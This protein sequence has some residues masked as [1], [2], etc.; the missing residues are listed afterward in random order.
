MEKNF[1]AE[2]EFVTKVLDPLAHFPEETDKF[3]SHP[4]Q[5]L[6]GIH[7]YPDKLYVITVLENPLRW[8]SRY[9]NYWDFHKHVTDSGAILLTVELA[10][11]GRAFE[12]T[13]PDDPFNVQLRT[14]DEMFHKENLGNIGVWRLPLGVRYVALMDADMIS[15]RP[16]W[17]QET[18]QQLQH[19]DVVQMFS[20]YSD[21]DGHHKAGPSMPS[22]MYNYFHIPDSGT[23]HPH[24]GHGRWLGAP[25]GAWAYRIEAF[26]ALGSLIDRCILGSAD[27]HMAYGLVQRTE[28]ASLH[29]EIQ[30]CSDEYRRYI[31]LWQKNAARL[32]RNIG[33]VENHMLHKYHGPRI[34]RGYSDR[35]KILERNQYDPFSDIMPDNHGVYEWT[36]TKPQLRDD[37]RRYFQSRNE[38][39]E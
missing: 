19:F 20:S 14:R 7:V 37:I 35:W 13:Q 27:G 31:L 12:V 22:F 15:T 32:N 1:N 36:G 34:L 38:D 29:R 28:I 25:G 23:P 8:R 39:G 9:R 30:E 21:V 17:A 18:L 33:Y 6:P 11:G 3:I 16:D 4:A 2:K 24:N 10:L 5:A 26:R